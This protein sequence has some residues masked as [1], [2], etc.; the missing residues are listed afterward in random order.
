MNIVTPVLIVCIIALIVGVILTIAAIV[1]KVKVDERF[2]EIREQLPGANCG[3]CGF[4]GCD[5][6]ANAL[7]G[8]QEVSP[9]LCTVGGGDLATAIAQVLGV[10]AGDVDPMIATVMCRGDSDA[11]RRLMKFDKNYGCKAATYLYGGAMACKY[12][13]LGLGDCEKVCP[14]DA[15]TIVNN[16]AQIDQNA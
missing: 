16:L 7:V 6:Y 12:G 15:I 2:V 13:C 4:A 8:D 5:D 3:A 10:A 11:R 9:S 1:M 14:K